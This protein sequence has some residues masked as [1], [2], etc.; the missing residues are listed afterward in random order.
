KSQSL[1]DLDGTEWN[2]FIDVLQRL[3]YGVDKAFKPTLFNWSCFKN[4]AYRDGEPNPEI[5]WHFLPR[6]QKELKFAGMTFKDPDFGYIPQ[7]IKHEVP[8]EVMEKIKATIKKY[9]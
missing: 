6:Y 7:P 5:H 2:D 3:E 8:E 9:L 4:K 1:S